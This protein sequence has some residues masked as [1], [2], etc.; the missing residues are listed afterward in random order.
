MEIIGVIK[1]KSLDTLG[2]IKQRQ[3]GERD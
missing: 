3:G 2:M 1:G